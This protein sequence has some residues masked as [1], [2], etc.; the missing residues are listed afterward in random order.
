MILI[1]II[2]ALIKEIHVC[3]R[4][5]TSRFGLS[6]PSS[7]DIIPPIF[8]FSL[9]CETIRIIRSIELSS[10]W[11]FIFIYFWL[12]ICLVFKSCFSYLAILY[13][14][15]TK[16]NLAPHWLLMFSLLSYYFS[17]YYLVICLPV[18]ENIITFTHRS[19][20]IFSAVCQCVCVLLVVLMVVL[21]HTDQISKNFEKNK[22]ICARTLQNVPKQEAIL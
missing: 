4:F 21:E 10:T 7:S 20:Q 15:V 12:R 13:R 17:Y 11:I 9:A 16:G 22:Q 19:C 14:S 1:F 3:R 5:L 2:L 8:A 18:H 6:E